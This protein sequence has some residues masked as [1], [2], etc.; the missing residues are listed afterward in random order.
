MNA[1]FKLGVGLVAFLVLSSLIVPAAIFIYELVSKPDFIDVRTAYEEFNETSVT[2]VFNVT[3]RGSVALKDVRFEVFKEAVYLGDL[4]RNTSLSKRLIVSRETSSE[5][6]EIEIS[7]KVA[8]IYG[9]ELR[10]CGV[11]E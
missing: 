3:Y 9:V 8:G 10:L 6:M 4:S 1:L 7:L 5:P 2:L 11:E